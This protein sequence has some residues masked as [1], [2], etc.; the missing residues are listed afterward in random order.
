MTTP[1][2]PSGRTRTGA[3]ITL[4]IGAILTIGGPVLGVLTGSLAMIPGALDLAD[5][6]AQVAPA[7]TIALEEGNSVFLL[8]PVPDLEH[9]DYEMCT[10]TGPDETS[11]L[12]KYEPA[13]ALNTLVDGTRYESFAR[14]TAV[15][16]GPQTIACPD[17]SDIPVIAAPPFRLG[18]VFGP[19][20]WGSIA[21]L[22]VSLAGVLMAIVGIVK[23]ARKPSTR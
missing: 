9:I 20:A 11:A 14:V 21:G 10:A 4:V 13:T 22:V 1:P 8:A 23:L 3:I 15:A 16:A 6:T 2:G 5:H 12:V 18:E 17:S 19:L 7:A